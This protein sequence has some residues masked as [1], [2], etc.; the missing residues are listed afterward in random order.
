M[1][2]QLS[3]S[4]KKPIIRFHCSGG[5][6]TCHQQRPIVFCRPIGNTVWRD[7]TEAWNQLADWLAGATGACAPLHCSDLPRPP[8]G[9]PKHHSYSFI[10]SLVNHTDC[11]HFRPGCFCYG[12]L[13]SIFSDRRKSRQQLQQQVSNQTVVFC[14]VLQQ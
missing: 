8:S 12:I 6:E 10:Y 9:R 14:P 3:A 2:G 13:N 7:V 4:V 1:S 5:P 11:K